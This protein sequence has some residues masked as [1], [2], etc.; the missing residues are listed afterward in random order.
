MVIV[1]DEMHRMIKYS[2]QRSNKRIGH[3]PR[4]VKKII[5]KRCTN[6]IGFCMHETDGHIMTSVWCTNK[7][8]AEEPAPNHNSA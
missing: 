1:K 4:W 7:S 3:K 2:S 5:D 8:I 6:D